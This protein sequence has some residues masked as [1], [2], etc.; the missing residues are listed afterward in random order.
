LKFVY[1]VKFTPLKKP[2]CS[3]PATKE[4]PEEV[5]LRAQMRGRLLLEGRWM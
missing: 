1:D 2:V 3:R 4:M 5:G